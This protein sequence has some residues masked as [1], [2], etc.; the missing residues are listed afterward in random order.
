MTAAFGTFSMLCR[1]R[2]CAS[3]FRLPAARFLTLLVVMLGGFS[4]AVNAAVTAVEPVS[5]VD[6]S[7]QLIQ[8]TAPARRI[9]ALAPHITE[10]LFFVGAGTQVVGIA[11]ASDFPS[12]VAR[13]PVVATHNDINLE[14]VV[15]LKPDAVIAWGRGAA[16]PK[17]EKLKALGLRVV[18][19]DPQTPA[20][21]ADNMQWMAQMAGTEVQ[22]HAAIEQWRTRLTQLEQQNAAVAS[23]YSENRPDD[24]LVFYQVWDRPLMT[25]NRKHLIAQGIKLCGGRVLFAEQLLQTPTVS[26]ESVVR[27]SPDIIVYTDDRKRSLDWGKQWMQWRTIRAVRSSHVFALPPDLLVRAGPRYLDGVE[28]LCDVMQRVKG[29]R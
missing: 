5:F 12:E 22:A 10:L 1:L 6:D 8:V 9:V 2:R 18:Y 3:L 24:P 21:I 23:G 15:R 14:A 17:L 25:V 13:L 26:V 29:A 20:A 4:A 27:A 19:S 11:Q 7:G 16:N 28:R